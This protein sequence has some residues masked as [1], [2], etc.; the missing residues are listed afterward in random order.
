MAR[1]EATVLGSTN[2]R[3]FCGWTVARSGAWCFAWRGILGLFAVLGSSLDV[4]AAG[5]SVHGASVSPAFIWQAPALS[6]MDTVFIIAATG[7]PR[8][9]TQRDSCEKILIA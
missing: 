9:K 8:F 4:S 1:R 3:P 5:P 2:K 7:E 6:R